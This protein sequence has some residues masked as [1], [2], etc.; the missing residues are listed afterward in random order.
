[1][2]PL[3]A[4]FEKPWPLLATIH[5]DYLPRLKW[6]RGR[7]NL[8]RRHVACLDTHPSDSAPVNILNAHG[9]PRTNSLARSLSSAPLQVFPLVPCHSCTSTR[10]SR[11]RLRLFAQLPYHR[12]EQRL[13]P[14]GGSTK[15][16]RDGSADRKCPDPCLLLA[17]AKGWI[18]TSEGR[19]DDRLT[20]GAWATV[21]AKD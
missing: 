3:G 1:M 5:L 8:T 21:R 19:H 9:S 13:G 11:S 20:S 2:C 6:Y 15:E 12:A 7:R 18:E 4:S 14:D 10:A 16:P 17:N